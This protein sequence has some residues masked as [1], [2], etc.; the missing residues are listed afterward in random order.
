MF[1]FNGVDLSLQVF[2]N[3]SNPT[4]DWGPVH[5][6]DRLGTRYERAT[7]VATRADD[8]DSDA[9]GK[10][11]DAFAEIYAETSIDAPQNNGNEPQY[12]EPTITYS[13]SYAPVESIKM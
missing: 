8:T 13:D 9:T 5:K 6:E 12:Q 10:V 7:D 2:K 1:H 4:S 11:N 3:I